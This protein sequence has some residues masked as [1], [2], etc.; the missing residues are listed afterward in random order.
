MTPNS[1]RRTS[2]LVSFFAFVLA[3]G[4]GNGDAPAAG[5]EAPGGGEVAFANE[6]NVDLSEMTRTETGL[7]IQDEA[8]GE[9]EP[10]RPGNAVLVHYTG[11]LPNGMKFDS[12]LDRN[13]PFVVSPVGTAQVI[14]GWNE[15]L[16]GM[17]PGGRRLL[18][19]PPNLAYGET[20]TLGGPIPP[21]ATLV[22]RVELL[23]ILP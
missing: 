14:A 12:S 18:V 7:Y 5:A 6:L 22:F 9:G 2:L 13:E 1:P 8:E 23:Q 20:G 19:L 3:A 10:V 4:C 15:G 17:R 21:N 16:Q 11:W